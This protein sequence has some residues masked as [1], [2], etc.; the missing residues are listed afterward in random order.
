MCDKHSFRDPESPVPAPGDEQKSLEVEIAEKEHK[1][2][3]RKGKYN[4]VL[5]D[6]FR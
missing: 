2:A 4:A 6:S 5:R 3:S 1:G